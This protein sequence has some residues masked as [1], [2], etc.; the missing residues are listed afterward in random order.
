MRLA[1]GKV[2][3]IMKRLK[4]LGMKG[5]GGQAISDFILGV[6]IYKVLVTL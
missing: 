4:E 1:S 3:S 5:E 6:S 2:V